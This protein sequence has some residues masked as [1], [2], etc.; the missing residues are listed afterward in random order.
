MFAHALTR[1]SAIDAVAPACSAY[2]RRRPVMSPTSSDPLGHVSEKLTRRAFLGSAGAAAAVAATGGAP[3]AAC[4]DSGPLH[5]WEAAQ[6]E[7][8]VKLLYASMTDTQK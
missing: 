5:K 8:T 4:I 3:L 2:K 1:R 6:P 7:S